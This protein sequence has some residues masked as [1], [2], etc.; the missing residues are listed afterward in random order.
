MPNT[1]RSILT[2]HADAHPLVYLSDGG[3]DW[4]AATLYDE[5]ESEILDEE[6]AYTTAPNGIVALVDGYMESSPAYRYRSAWTLADKREI[7][8]ALPTL[9][10]LLDAVKQTEGLSYDDNF[11]GMPNFGGAEP[12]DTTG[13][14]SWD[15]TRLLVGT[16]AADMEIVPRE[17]R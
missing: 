5:L 14:W 9:D 13:I 15:A 4:F 10:D 8:L 6:D 1:L 2:H 11:D 17:G 3:T 12:D 7:A 16:C